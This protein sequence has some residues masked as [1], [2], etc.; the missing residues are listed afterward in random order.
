M[1]G[2]KLALVEDGYEDLFPLPTLSMEAVYFL[3]ELT[4][5]KSSVIWGD[6]SVY[7]NKVVLRSDVSKCTLLDIFCEGQFR[8][9]FGVH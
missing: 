6:I 8:G 1:F 2:E 3:E 7:E 5:K 4:A 9:A